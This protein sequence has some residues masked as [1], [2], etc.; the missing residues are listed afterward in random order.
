MPYR[1]RSLVRTLRCGRAT[2]VVGA[3]GMRLQ[4]NLRCARSAGRDRDA[5]PP[6]RCSMPRIIGLRGQAFL[7]TLLPDGTKEYA[8]TAVRPMRLAFRNWFAGDLNLQNQ[9]IDSL[10]LLVQRFDLKSKNQK[11]P[12]RWLGFW[13]R[14]WLGVPATIS[15]CYEAAVGSADPWAI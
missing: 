12:L 13:Y 7:E 14:S 6:S 1:A 4:Q 9:V 11:N 5:R 3:N 15:N 2:Y 10:I 8:I